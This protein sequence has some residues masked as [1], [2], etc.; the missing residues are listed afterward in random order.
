MLKEI[1]I[2]I[3]ALIIVMQLYVNFSQNNLVIPENS[4]KDSKDKSNS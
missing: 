2:S 4:K 3:I 1:T